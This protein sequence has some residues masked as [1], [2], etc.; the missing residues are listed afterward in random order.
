MIRIDYDTNLCTF[1]LHWPGEKAA[2][3]EV[4]HRVPRAS[5]GDLLEVQAAETAAT[6]APGAIIYNRSLEFETMKDAK[7]AR[8]LAVAAIKAVRSKR[9][10]AAWEAKA[11]A[12][13]WK[14]PRGR[15]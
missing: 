1:F 12:A 13:G 3:L 5:K 7:V 9:K 10:P 11:L 4:C 2:R 15:R 14:P 6:Q 8:T